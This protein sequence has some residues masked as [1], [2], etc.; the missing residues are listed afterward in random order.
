MSAAAAIIREAVGD[1][2]VLTPTPAGTFK[3][4]GPD[5]VLARWRPVLAANKAAIVAELSQDTG[6]TKWEMSENVRG[7]SASE[8]VQG[9]LDDMTAENERRRDWWR[10]PVEGWPYRLTIRSVLT[11]ETV[12]IQLRGRP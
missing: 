2:L 12:V 9:L 1:G 6:R 7:L 3:A 10:Y 4:K 11:G 8:N 5:S